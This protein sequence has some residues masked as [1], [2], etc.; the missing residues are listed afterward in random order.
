MA[1]AAVAEVSPIPGSTFTPKEVNDACN[2]LGLSKEE[3]APIFFLIGPKT[4]C[5]KIVF[6]EKIRV[7]SFHGETIK[8]E[9]NEYFIICKEKDITQEIHCLRMILR[10]L[11]IVEIVGLVST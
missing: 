1:A 8:I 6:P 5:D 4:F 9:D 10:N 11:E 2:L 7:L 3:L